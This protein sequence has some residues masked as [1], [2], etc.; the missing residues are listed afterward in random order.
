[1]PR[2]PNLLDSPL[3]MPLER[4]MSLAGQFTTRPGQ[5]STW[6]WAQPGISTFQPSLR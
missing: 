3:V 4:A 5:G 2:L 1:M 6:G